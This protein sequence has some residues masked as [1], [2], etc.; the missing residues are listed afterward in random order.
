MAYEPGEDEAFED[1]EG[2]QACDLAGS[3]D[4]DDYE[5]VP[6]P[7]CGREISELAEQCPHCGQWIVHGAAGGRGHRPL[8]I[9][10]A[11]LLLLSLLLWIL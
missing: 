3:G 2:P 9:V 7:H 10:I 8:L 1:P 6:C 4:S 11:I 5:V